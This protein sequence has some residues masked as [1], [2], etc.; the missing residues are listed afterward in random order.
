M[1]ILDY[2]TA[3]QSK[4]TSASIRLSYNTPKQKNITYM[5]T[6]QKINAKQHSAYKYLY[7]SNFLIKYLSLPHS[8]VLE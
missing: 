2:W 4:T 7:F 6:E 8:K 5:N 3:N 1:R